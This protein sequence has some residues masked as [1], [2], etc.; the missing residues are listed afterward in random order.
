MAGIQIH[1]AKITRST[2][3]ESRVLSVLYYL[4]CQD[5]GDI[6]VSLLSQLPVLVTIHIL[7]SRV[8]V[9]IVQTRANPRVPLQYPIVTVFGCPGRDPR[10]TFSGRSSDVSSFDSYLV[11]LRKQIII[12]ALYSCI[13]CGIYPRFRRIAPQFLPSGE[14]KH[15]SRGCF[16][17]N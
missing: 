16:Y 7:P 2:L 4:G 11:A 10:I 8:H 9:G 6:E 5:E 14:L 13:G 1:L 3:C 15:R 17:A 12:L